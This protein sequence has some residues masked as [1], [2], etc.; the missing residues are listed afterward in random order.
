MLE[1]VNIDTG[2]VLPLT[3]T[4]KHL[5]IAHLLLEVTRKRVVNHV[6]AH[7]VVAR[8]VGSHHAHRRTHHGRHRRHHEG[9]GRRRGHHGVVVGAAERIVTVVEC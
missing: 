3:L 5:V 8:L 4:V 1:K 6:T 7:W 9:V 2:L